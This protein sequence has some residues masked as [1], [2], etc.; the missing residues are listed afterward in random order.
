[1]MRGVRGALLALV[2][3]LAVLVPIRG[4][5]AR[6]AEP[7]ALVLSPVGAFQ[8]P[9]YVASPFGDQDRLFVVQ[10]G[11]VITLVLDGVI[12]TTPLLN[13]TSLLDSGPVVRGLLWIPLPPD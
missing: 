12:R 6:V 1:M 13:V 9:T 5:G 8:E 11:G 10:K 3:G 2:L 7:D 4:A